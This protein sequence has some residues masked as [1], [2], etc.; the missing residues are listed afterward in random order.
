MKRRQ[1]GVNGPQV[2]SIGLGCMGMSEFYGPANDEESKATI[3]AALENGITMLDTADTYGF[4]H[5]E[6]LIAAALADW[7]DEVFIATKFGII[8]EKGRYERV[9]SGRP[10]YVKK[11]AEDSLRRLRREAI[12]LFYIHRIDAT[13]PIEDTVGAMADLVD[14]GKVRYIGIS[15]ASPATIRRAHAVHPLT[16]VQ[17]EYSLWTRD[18]EKEV[19]PLLHELGIGF[20]PYSPLG[21]GFLTGKLDL[22]AIKHDT[23]FRSTLPRLQGENYQYNLALVKQLEAVAQELGIQTSQLALAWV[24]SRDENFIPIPGTRH[25]SY[26]L[27]N[28]AATEL[29]VDQRE[30]GFL[31]QIFKSEAVKGERY[32]QAGMVGINA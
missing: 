27:E 23:D 5:N 11:S 12:D 29:Q 22:Q 6:E 3:R 4:G 16:A 13:V 14:A 9:V 18:V 7:P 24:L 2:S 19:V 10:E 30:L 25:T 21:R 8:R 20:V 28:I 32:S 17:T 31:D 1:L 26:L 15:E